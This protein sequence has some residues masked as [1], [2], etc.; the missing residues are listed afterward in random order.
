MPVSPFRPLRVLAVAALAAAALAADAAA[1]SGAAPAARRRRPQQQQPARTEAARTETVGVS[2]LP[3]TCEASVVFDGY[4]PLADA[5]FGRSR[6]D[7]VR[8]LLERGGVP[9]AVFPLSALRQALAEP[10]LVAHMVRIA[11][12]SKEEKA[13]VE[14]FVARGGRLVVYESFSPE[15]AALFGLVPPR[16]ERVEPSAAGDAWTGFALASPVPLHA[17]AFLPNRTPRVPVVRAASSGT[18]AVASWR[19]ERG[20]RGPPALF[21]A[22]CGFWLAR[23]L[24]DDAPA[25]D[26]SR[27]LL[28]L[29]CTLSPPLWRVSARTLD[30]SL[31]APAGG[32]RSRAEAERRLAAAAGPVREEI[33]HGLFRDVRALEKG[34]DEL[35]ARGLYG[36]SHTNLWEIGRRVRLAYAAAHPLPA[37]SP[38][39]VLAVWEPTGYGPQSAGGWDAAARA[40][41]AAGVT[42][43]HLWAGSLGGAVADLPGVPPTDARRL[44][45][46]PFPAAVAACRRYG[47]R[48]HAWLGT[49]QFRQPD[50]ARRAAFVRARRL[51]HDANGAPTDWL[52]P[53][54]KANADDLSLVVRA[55]AA[56][57]V[58]GV[59][60]DFL[61]YPDAPT[62]EKRSAEAVTALLARL[63]AD[64][65]AAAPKCELSVAVY[66][67]YPACAN[68][69]GQDWMLWL[70]RGLADRA[71]PMNY[72]SDLAGLRRLMGMQ[73]RHRDRLLC[74][75]GASARESALD[76]PALMDQLRE[77]YA[78]GYRGAAVYSFDDRFFG[79]F[80]P[81]FLLA[82]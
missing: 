23:T 22:P 15:L 26:R 12:L 10:C 9:A 54:V 50:D 27:L 14:A 57:G 4:A 46:N 45:G 33:V 29:S 30:E 80:V 24:Y 20:Q 42:D 55:L 17:P 75:I 21:R 71:M 31:W 38:G 59:S 2:P 52:D 1:A 74:G 25:D 67:G 66:G 65:R 6:A 35:F 28:S 62:R 8:S 13:L 60:L 3:K 72:V 53:A 70:D 39:R 7:N 81:A 64:L 37:P 34:K 63:R 56:S 41:A 76:V 48:V 82:Q 69:V 40:L 36:A 44:R 43:L 73:T 49:L 18:K 58:D 79:E 77:A 61:R 19:S 51:L 16:E 68:N 32:A 11:R 78:Q 47:V 5:R